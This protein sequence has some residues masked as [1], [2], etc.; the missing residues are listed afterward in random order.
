MQ[1]VHLIHW[2]P[3]EVDERCARIVAAGYSASGDPFG[4]ALLKSLKEDPPDALVIDLSR[5]PAQGR[6]VGLHLRKMKDT[7][8]IPLVFVEG[9]PAKV[10]RIREV[11]PDARY[12]DWSG[13]GAALTAAINQAP[14]DPVVP[15]SVFA[16]YAGTPLPKKLGIKP[17]MVV[18]LVDAPDDFEETLGELPEDAVLRR[19][20][21]G[22]PALTL[23][24]VTSR[25]DLD[26][27]LPR[28]GRH[29]PNAGLWICWPKKASG[30]ESDLSQAAVRRAGLDAGLMDFK[31]C[32]VDET[33]SGLRF[34]IPRKQ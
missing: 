1:H 26:R 25:K 24:F 27:R 14:S 8:H 29:A 12:S 19:N 33:W 28:M 5:L 22:D 32:A 10:A 11:L 31:I 21:R 16:P 17:G 7:R 30:V 2:K 9:E 34:T 3:N 18:A 13:I 20:L 4:P 6:D 15:D 23:W